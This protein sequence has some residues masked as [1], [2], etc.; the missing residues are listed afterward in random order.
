MTADQPF[1]CD[2]LILYSQ[3][4]DNKCYITTA[5]LDG[6]TNLKPKEVPN[7]LPEFNVEDI[8]N[9][10]AVIEYEKPNENLYD[11]VGKLVVN[12]QEQYLIFFK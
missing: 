8:N 4:E 7:G 9:L 5:N 1:P 3:T 6:E 11:F 10:E 12:N 2:L